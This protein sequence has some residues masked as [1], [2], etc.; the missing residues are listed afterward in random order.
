MMLIRYYSE[1]ICMLPSSK[2]ILQF[3]RFRRLVY[4]LNGMIT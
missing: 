3:F 4:F 1:K 2:P